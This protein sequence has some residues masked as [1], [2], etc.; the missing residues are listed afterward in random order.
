MHILSRAL[1]SRLL[2]GGLLATL[3]L[4]AQTSVRTVKVLGSKDAVELEVEA[5]DRIVPQTQVLTGPDRLVIDFPNA[6]PS[7]QLRSQSVDRGE[8]KDVRVG[9]FQGKPP[10]TRLVLDLKT[11]QSYQVFPNGRTVIIKVLG[12]GQ[13]TSARA[14]NYRPATVTGPGL[15]VANYTTH[16]EPVSIE[17]SAKPILDVSFSDGLLGIRA[18]KVTLSQVLFAV[19]QRTGAEVSIAA[20]AEQEQVVAD[21]SPAPAQEVLARLLNG[22]HFN[23]LILSAND[24][25]RQLD[26]VILSPRAEGATMPLP[27]MPA[28]DT[29]ALGDDALPP[30]EPQAPEIAPGQVPPQS[31]EMKSSPD[32]NPPDSN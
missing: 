1:I 9:L 21:I 15:V 5:S 32:N 19:Q 4:W 22:S 20:G 8:V 17:N 27:Q 28:Q 23:F 10:V 26:R 14:D 7:N 18:S 11:A 16:A 12:G 29:A 6:V 30:R 2:V 31:P 13:E 25:P 24:D 3:P